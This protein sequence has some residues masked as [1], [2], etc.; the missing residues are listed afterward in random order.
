MGRGTAEHYN[1]EHTVDII[2]GTF[3]KALASSGDFIAGDN[4]VIDYL[5]HFASSFVFS[6]SMT[7]SAVATVIASLEIL[8]REPKRRERLLLLSKYTRASLLTAGFDVIDGLTPAIVVRWE[9]GKDLYGRSEEVGQFCNDLLEAGFY[10]NPIMG[11]AVPSPVL[12]INIMVVHTESQIDALV[13]AMVEASPARLTFNLG[14]NL[15][16]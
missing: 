2:S 12:R 7:P 4:D 14:N 1:V 6:A 11:Q 13:H 15:N 9:S 16:S 3:S 8:Q 5:K 10:I